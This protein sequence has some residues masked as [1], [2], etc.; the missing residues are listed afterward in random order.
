[1][2]ELFHLKENG[3]LLEKNDLSQKSNSSQE[4]INQQKVNNRD[5]GNLHARLGRVETDH[6]GFDT[7]NFIFC[8]TKASIK[9]VPTHR[10]RE[11][12]C[13]IILANTYHLLLSPG[14]AAIAKQGGLHKFM[15]WSGPMLT[16]SGGYQIFAMGHGSVAKEIKRSHNSDGVDRPSSLVAITDKGAVFRSY[17]DGSRVELT[18]EKAISIQCDLGADII[19]QLDECTPYHVDKEYTQRAMI[20][21][22]SWGD[23]SLEAFLQRKDADDG[24]GNKRHRQYLAGVV[25]GGVYRDLRAQSVDYVY[26]RNFDSVALGGSL[27]KSKEEMREVVS[28]TMEMVRSYDKK[29]VI[30]HR[31]LLGIGGIDDVF[32]G[33]KQGIDTFDCVHPTRMARHGH[34]IVPAFL[35][36]KMGID[37][38]VVN[39]KNARCKHS[40]Q[41]LDETS[42]VPASKYKLAYLHHLLKVKEIAALNILTEHNVAQ[43]NRLFADI[44]KA[45]LQGSLDEVQ[46]FWLG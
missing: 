16:D 21:S 11:L 22:M 3:D 8:A 38:H 9:A 27:G 45:I 37:G 25:Q 39:L 15:A 6:G 12:G 32:F 33:V 26:D 14:S 7:P 19:V 40:D 17:V 41:P 18:P 28:M 2:G 35:L 23:R 24:K 36:Q 5:S 46:R 43:I 31:H 44:R 42:P 29:G 13:D 20:R 1:M 30:K 10:L 4:T 34:A